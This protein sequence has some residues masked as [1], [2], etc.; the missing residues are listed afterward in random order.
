[1]KVVAR[2]SNAFKSFERVMKP[3]DWWVAWIAGVL[4]VASIVI[5]AVG[6]YREADTRQR[7]AIFN[8]WQIVAGMEEKRAEGGRAEALKELISHRESLAGVDLRGA[9]LEKVDFSRTDMRM[10]KLSEVEFTACPMLQVNFTGTTLENG[11][12]V[13]GCNLTGAGFNQTSIRGTL[14][15]QAVMFR[16]QFRD[17]TGDVN[18]KFDNVDLREAAV[19]NS[20]LPGAMFS[21]VLCQKAKFNDTDLSSARFKAVIANGWRWRT[22][23]APGAAF[24]DFVGQGAHFEWETDLREAHFDQADL[25]QAHFDGVDLHE[26]V[27]FG[28]DL[29]AATFARSNLSGADFTSA[30]L[31]NTRFVGCNIDGATFTTN[32]EK[33]YDPRNFEKCTGKPNIVNVAARP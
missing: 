4:T 19:A 15:S 24:E 33:H 20:H 2:I 26:A 12:F 14:F 6:Y 10:A 30:T 22:V 21:N 9:I 5:T 23:T 8:A 28:A 7:A 29:T 17:T 32:P 11:W 13:A 31:L 25:R 27:F 16:V 18:T 3:Y 1:M